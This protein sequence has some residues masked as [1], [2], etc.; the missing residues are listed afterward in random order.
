MKIVLKYVGGPSPGVT[1]VGERASLLD[2]S[3][4]LRKQVEQIPEGKEADIPLVD[5]I[6]PGPSVEWISVRLVQDIGPMMK[7][8]TR[9]GIWL[10]KGIW[11]AMAVILGILILALI[12]FMSLL[13]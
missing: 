7:V 9:K 13:R 2:L 11:V 6:A 5:S 8:E 4:V 3:D 1:I 10:V 12:G